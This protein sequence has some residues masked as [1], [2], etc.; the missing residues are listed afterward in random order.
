MSAELLGPVILAAAAGVALTVAYIR[1]AAAASGSAVCPAPAL[2]SS[3]PRPARP[4]GGPADDP[5]S[6]KP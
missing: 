5:P 3:S 6:P 2:P 4:V 1:A